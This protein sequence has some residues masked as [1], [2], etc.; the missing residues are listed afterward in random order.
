[1]KIRLGTLKKLIS[2]AGQSSFWSNADQHQ[3]AVGWQ[4][5]QQHM[6]QDAVDAFARDVIDDYEMDPDQFEFS[7]ESDDGTYQAH[8]HRADELWQWDGSRWVLSNY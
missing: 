2:E 8:S 5:A 3:L 1:M 6:P 7:L 4:E